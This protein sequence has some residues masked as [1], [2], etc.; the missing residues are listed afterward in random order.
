MKRNR[1]SKV[2]K[3]HYPTFEDFNKAVT[4]YIHEDGYKINPIRKP[5]GWVSW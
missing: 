1:I 4:E 3:E 5:D 2:R